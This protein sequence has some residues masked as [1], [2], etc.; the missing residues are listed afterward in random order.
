[1]PIHEF[2]C[3]SCKHTFELLIMSSDEMESVRCSKC[4]S[5]EVNKLMSAANVAV[6]DNGGG[7]SSQPASEPVQHRSCGS[8][9]CTTINLPGHER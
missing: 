8:G 2:Q 4:H 1:M 9:S 3:G 5:P 6:G 7:A